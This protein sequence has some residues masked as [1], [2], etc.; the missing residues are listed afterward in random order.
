MNIIFVD[1]IARE[2]VEES[3]ENLINGLPEGWMVPLMSL[4]L[5]EKREPLP[6][7]VVVALSSKDSYNRALKERLEAKAE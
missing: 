3:Q 4:S 5:D 7:G 6:Y 2:V 1:P